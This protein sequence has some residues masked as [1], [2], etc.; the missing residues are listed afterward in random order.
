MINSLNFSG[1]A[2]SKL[3]GTTWLVAIL[4]LSDGT[5]IEKVDYIHA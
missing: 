4:E 2:H 1:I 3:H 5:G